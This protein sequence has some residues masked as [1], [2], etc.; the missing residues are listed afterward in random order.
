MLTTK[1]NPREPPG[2]QK[3]FLFQWCFYRIQNWF[4]F[5]G[6]FCLAGL[7]YELTNQRDNARNHSKSDSPSYFTTEE[8]D[9]TMIIHEY[10]P[11]K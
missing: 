6:R 8:C 9:F 3:S 4:A 1:Q 11:G 2:F 7:F 10:D 5:H